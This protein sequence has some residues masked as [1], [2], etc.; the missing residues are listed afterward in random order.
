MSVKPSEVA[1]GAFV[2][3]RIV[4]HHWPA[5]VWAHKF[6]QQPLRF[7]AVASHGFVLL[8]IA[9]AWESDHGFV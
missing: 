5:V 7:D 6:I 1:L 2:I 4:L 3:V 8:F 9:A